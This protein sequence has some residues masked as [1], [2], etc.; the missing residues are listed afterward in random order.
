MIALE[1][2]R[3]EN[4]YQNRAGH[5][6]YERRTQQAINGINLLTN[7]GTELRSTDDDKVRTTV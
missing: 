7:D 3:K 1:N 5:F 6:T 4:G 2:Q